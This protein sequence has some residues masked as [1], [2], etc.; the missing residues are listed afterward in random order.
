MKIIQIVLHI[1]FIIYLLTLEPFYFSS[2]YFSYNSSMR[3]L[4]GSIVIFSA[5]MYHYVTNMQSSQPMTINVNVMIF[6]FLF[7]T[8]D[9]SISLIRG[10]GHSIDLG[11]LLRHF[12]GVITFISF[13]SQRNIWRAS[14]INSFII[15]FPLGLYFL[16]FSG[17][18]TFDA[19]ILPSRTAS[20]VI[21]YGNTF[22]TTF[23]VF[24]PVD[25]L[26]RRFAG[27]FLEPGILAFYTIIVIYIV[28]LNVLPKKRIVN[29]VLYASLSLTKSPLIVI[30]MIFVRKKYI[31]FFMAF[32]G[33]LIWFMYLFSGFFEKIIS[34]LIL[35]IAGRFQT[36]GRASQTLDNV[37]LM[38]DYNIWILPYVLIIFFIFYLLVLFKFKKH[39]KTIFIIFLL[40]IISRFDILN[41]YSIYILSLVL[42]MSKQD[43]IK[44][45]KEL[46]NNA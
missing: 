35:K 34:Y 36:S 26:G 20:T 7:S 37:S 44:N 19:S 2:G 33:V 29:L 38:A 3:I 8:L 25:F 13:F 31:I 45:K 24:E 16:E 42:T 23:I 11:Y 15:L 22:L 14:N 46:L 32:W 1:S 5:F 28:S 4:A 43:T 21:S 39:V 6:I 30:P 40:V 27:W 12:I 10:W 9:L 17:L 41:W 18:L